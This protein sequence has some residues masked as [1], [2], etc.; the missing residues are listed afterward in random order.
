MNQIRADTRWASRWIETDPT[1][2]VSDAYR[3]TFAPRPFAPFRPFAAAAS[4]ARS[5]APS[6]AASYEL[7]RRRASFQD[8]QR[9]AFFF[10]AF[11]RVEHGRHDRGRA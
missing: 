5:A 6:A 9:R 2:A 8:A 10:S 11:V 4:C 7:R 3:G 1:R